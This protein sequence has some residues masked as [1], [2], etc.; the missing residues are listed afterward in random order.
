MVAVVDERPGGY[1]FRGRPKDVARTDALRQ[2]PVDTCGLAGFAGVDPVGMPPVAD[3]QVQADVE[4]GS[5][6]CMRRLRDDAGHH[7]VCP[8][9]VLRHGCRAGSDGE[10]SEP[11]RTGRRV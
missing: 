5:G 6:R 8:H 3:I 10:G 2:Y 4:L 11:G 1:P 7:V 9:R